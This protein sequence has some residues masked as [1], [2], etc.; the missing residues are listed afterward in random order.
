MKDI[1]DEKSV[2]VLLLGRDA[3]GEAAGGSIGDAVGC[4]G[5]VDTED[6]GCR[7]CVGEIERLC[8]SGWNV[9]DESGRWIVSSKVVE[10]IKETSTR[11]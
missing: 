1:E 3:D 10:V 11:I 2:V 8:L 5:G 7:G 9:V 4:D 6:S